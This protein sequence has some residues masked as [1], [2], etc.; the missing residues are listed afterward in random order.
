MTDEDSSKEYL[1]NL[2]DRLVRLTEVLGIIVDKEDEIL[3]SDIEALI[4]ERQ[5]A[6][7]EKNFARA[8]EIRDELLAKGIVLKDTREGVQWKRA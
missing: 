2:F 4:A 5:A 8:D 3:D 7:K 1:E 6:R